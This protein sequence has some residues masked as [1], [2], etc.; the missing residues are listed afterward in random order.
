VKYVEENCRKM[1]RVFDSKETRKK[2][3][4]QDIALSVESPP[5]ACLMY[6]RVKRFFYTPK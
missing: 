4:T 1:R 3:K 6:H 2:N 5:S